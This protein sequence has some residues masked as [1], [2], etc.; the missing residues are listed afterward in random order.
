MNKSKLCECG[1]GKLASIA[2]YTDKRFG[3]IKGQPIRF[4]NGH[5]LRDQKGKKH[6]NWNGGITKNNYGR[7]LIH[8]PDH[9]RADVRGYVLRTILVAEKALRKSLPVKAVVHHI[10]GIVNNDKNN[11]LMICENQAYHLFLHQRKRAYDACRNVHWR[12]CPYCKIY[13]DP[14]NMYIYPNQ[15]TAL[16]RACRQRKGK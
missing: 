1:C 5:C 10:D 11:N 2:K 14:V 7:I 4:I 16:H 12:K 6:P 15:N 13:D 8:Q 3:H 9:K